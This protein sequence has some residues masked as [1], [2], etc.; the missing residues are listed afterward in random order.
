MLTEAERDRIRRATEQGI[1]N[2]KRRS[3]AA[4]KGLQK[5]GVPAASRERTSRAPQFEAG[6]I[7]AIAGAVPALSTSGRAQ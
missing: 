3:G 4:G 1:V 6:N 7:D 5:W 2:A